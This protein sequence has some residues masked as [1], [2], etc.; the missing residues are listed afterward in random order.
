MHTR[1]KAAFGDRSPEE[2]RSE[3]PWTEGIPVP[4]LSEAWG[5]DP[6][7]SRSFSLVDPITRF[8]GFTRTT[9]WIADR[10]MMACP[11][12]AFVPVTMTLKGP[13][14]QVSVVVSSDQDCNCFL[15]VAV[16]GPAVEKAFMD[17]LTPLSKVLED[18]AGPSN[19]TV[20]VV[21]LPTAQTWH[22][23]SQVMSSTLRAVQEGL[24][25]K[26][27]DEGWTA[28][29]RFAATQVC[30]T[31]LQNL[32]DGPMTRAAEKQYSEEG[33]DWTVPPPASSQGSG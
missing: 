17:S 23:F 8:P 5:E 2:L 32:A 33:L 18:S 9:E 20:S 22:A 12:V 16:R 31:A 11:D 30:E 29:M 6:K 26:A 25:Q 7:F 27:V 15:P 19:K 21:D 1:F 4:D 10:A 14:T 28:E 3:H 24:R 13:R